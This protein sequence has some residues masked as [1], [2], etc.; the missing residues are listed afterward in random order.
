[1]PRPAFEFATP[2]LIKAAVL[3]QQLTPEPDLKNDINAVDVK[4]RSKPLSLGQRDTKPGVLP[5]HT[6]WRIGRK[7]NVMPVVGAVRFV[8]PKRCA[9]SEERG[10]APAILP[11]LV[12]RLHG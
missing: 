10:V 5:A 4:G 2:L 12:H 9:V 7:G 6:P 11:T 8:Q 3:V 1:M